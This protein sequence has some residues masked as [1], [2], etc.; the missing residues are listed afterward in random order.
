MPTKSADGRVRRGRC[1]MS[2]IATAAS[3]LVAATLAVAGTAT[4]ARAAVPVEI[5]V[6][7]GVPSIQGAIDAA[8]DGDTVVVAAGTY[9]EHIDFKGKA[10]EVRSEIGAPST[11]I[12]GDG[13]SHVV[14]FHTG[15]GRGS[16][17]RGFTITHGLV[18]VTLVGGGVSIENASPT[19]V[20][21]TIA[22]NDAASH[23]GAG[24]GVAEGSPLIID[25]HIAGN[26]T[27]PAGAGGGILAV[28]TAEIIGNFITANW[29]GGGGGVLVSGGVLLADNI[30]YGNHAQGFDGGGVSLGGGHP[31]VVQ[32]VIGGNTADVRGGGVSWDGIGPDA[33]PEIV[34]NSIV[35]NH[36]PAGSAVAGGGGGAILTNN[37]IV[38]TTGS[39]T[40]E[41]RDTAVQ[42]AQFRHND[43]YGGSPPYAGCADP[44]G[45]AGNISVDPRLDTTSPIDGPAPTYRLL[46]GSPAMDAGDAS[47]SVRPLDIDGLDRIADGDGDGTEVVDMG[48][49]EAQP[50]VTLQMP[51]TVWEQ[52]STAPLDGLG[53]WVWPTND[54]IPALGQV[55]PAYLFSHHFGFVDGGGALGQVGLTAG[56]T[57]RIA[58]FSVVEPGGTEHVAAI[59]FDWSVGH[60]YFPMVYQLGPGSWGAWVWDESAATWTEIGV[61]AL[62]SGWGKLAPASITSVSWFGPAAGDCSLYPL[63]DIWF[64][65]PFGFIGGTGSVATD[66]ATGAGPGD[67]PASSFVEGSWSG[68]RVG[69]ASARTL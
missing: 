44:T 6:P 54:G 11:T 56:P 9:H 66:T 48:A 60:Y 34:N 61:L 68:H 22:G 20:G 13:T 53:S 57:G 24:I 52:P 67:C 41:C 27:D 15:E 63:A 59:P 26:Q 49:Y 39:S 30:I 29:A 10:I 55:L 31:R 16:V 1:G 21:N 64:H 40:V 5:H 62:P 2:G 51:Y 45:T 38:G 47:V 42:L 18:A 7:A 25:N 23:S 43:V 17:L 69:A 35:D 4:Q 36:A 33:A 14:R 3:M 65:A 50:L 8:S 12:D 37:V 19:I 46:P 28:G 32:N 58:V